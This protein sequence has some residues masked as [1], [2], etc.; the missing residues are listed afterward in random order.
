MKCVL[1]RVL[2]FQLALCVCLAQQQHI[3]YPDIDGFQF[4]GA[5]PQQEMVYQQEI[6]HHEDTAHEQTF[7]AQEEIMHQKE[8][9]PEPPHD[10]LQKEVERPPLFLVGEQM[11]SPRGHKPRPRC[12][13]QDSCQTAD[14]SHPMRGN[15]PDFPPGKPSRDNIEIICLEERVRAS[16]GPHNLPQTGFSHLSRQGDAITRIEEGFSQCCYEKDKLSCAQKVW[17]NGLDQYCEDEFSVKTRHHQCCKRTGSEREACFQKEAPDS[18]YDSMIAQ[19]AEPLE[20]ESDDVPVL[21]NSRSLSPCS[22][23]QASAS[24]RCRNTKPGSRRKV[25]VPK[26]SFPPGEPTDGCIQ[27]I[28]RLRKF[29][30]QYTTKDYPQTGY[31]WLHRQIKAINRMENEFKKCCKNENVTCAHEVWEDALLDF[32][33]QEMQVKTRHYECCDEVEHT[34]QLACFANRAT[35]PNYDKELKTIDLGFINATALTMICG[36]A[37]LQTKQK[38]IPLLVKTLTDEC[39]QLPTEEGVQCAEE[40]KASF[41]EVLCST[42]KDSWKDTEKCCSKLEPERAKCFNL[43]YLQNIVVANSGSEY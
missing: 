3:R 29:R 25:K 15:L 40:K 43:N 24:G 18:G 38:Q 28:C 35:H 13:D 37:K 42:K 16:Y 10:I 27:N 7:V 12:E 26:L 11:F 39:C 9:L 41:I 23:D 34:A 14:F 17:K 22:E 36:N 33:Q 4:R 30:P 8:E 1:G 31:G 20:V 6:V 21:A 2:A 19:P 32:C 5:R